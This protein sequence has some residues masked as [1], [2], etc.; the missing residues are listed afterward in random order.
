MAVPLVTPLVL[1]QMSAVQGTVPERTRTEIR[2]HPS[3]VARDALAHP[4]A[5]A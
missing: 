4:L 3:W 1:Q 2:D 5:V